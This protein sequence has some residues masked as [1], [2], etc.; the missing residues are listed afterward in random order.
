MSVSEMVWDREMGRETVDRVYKSVS[1]CF[2][3]SIFSG[4]KLL[5][6]FQDSVIVDVPEF[7][8]FK[9]KDLGQVQD[10]LLGQSPCLFLFNIPISFETLPN[11]FTILYPVCQAV[12]L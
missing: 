5:E 12:L 1:Q 8:F 11:T 2:G 9:I 4:K 3:D 6:T 7:H 10:A